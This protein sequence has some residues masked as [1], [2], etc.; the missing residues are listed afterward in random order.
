VRRPA[1]IVITVLVLTVAA[2]AAAAPPQ[3][4]AQESWPGGRQ[5]DPR[6]ERTVTLWGTGVPAAEVF[7]SI[8]K[9]TGVALGFDPP[10]DDNARICLN[11][12]LNPKEPPTL[13]E[14]LVQI[15][16][17]MDC[18]WG[19]EGEGEQ[20]RYVLLHTSGGSGALADWE[21]WREQALTQRQEREA[22]VEQEL[23]W[24]T[25]ARLPELREALDLSQEEAVRRYAGDPML[26]TLLDPP[27]RAVARFMLSLPAARIAELGPRMGSGIEWGELTAEQR[28]WLREAMRPWL[29]RCAVVPESERGLEYPWYDPA[30]VDRLGLQVSYHPQPTGLYVEV[31]PLI[32]WQREHSD[33]EMAEIPLLVLVRDPRE[34]LQM[35]ACEAVARR[36]FLGETIT[37]EQARR[38]QEAAEESRWRA[39]LRQTMDEQ[40]AQY[41]RVSAEAAARL[42]AVALPIEARQPYALWQLQEAVAAQSGFSMVS[43]CLWQPERS[44][45]VARRLLFP[46]AAEQL[47]AFSVLTAAC[48]AS[49]EPVGAWVSQPERA[50]CEWGD[51]GNILR[52]RSADRALWREAMLPRAVRDA[53]DRWMEPYLP[54][55]SQVGEEPPVVTVPLDVRGYA[56][57]VASLT[58]AQLA[59]G[60][61]LIYGDPTD[62]RNAYRQAMAR[63]FLGSGSAVWLASRIISSLD[64]RRWQQLQG[65][66]LVWGK[67][68]RIEPTP[69]DRDIT[70]NA[71]REG[72]VLHYEEGPALED[73]S[74]RRG[75]FYAWR[76]GWDAPN[77]HPP[78]D[79]PVPVEARLSL[80]PPKHL[81]P[82]PDGATPPLP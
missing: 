39:A 41:R 69:A 46:D 24:Q 45:I 70:W 30:E 40:L 9:Q 27:R 78:F 22:A 6:L 4:L 5:Y 66:G 31:S 38:I 23:W 63:E 19:V 7:A 64:D 15:G 8:T 28:E 11:A 56:P 61:N 2:H 57:L 68:V 54:G 35:P 37:D 53:M 75:R 59:F 43:D 26:L 76:D 3:W 55:L 52:F 77:V 73:Q 81:I 18:A 20:S 29:D 21:K 33:F 62:L 71:Y 10:D 74:H 48:V 42:S 58:R 79:D 47:D 34:P 60:R 12:Y 72:D 1:L 13:R 14:V 49:A 65:E 16:W 17:V 67:D 32:A 80:S 25:V 36:R 82:L 44:F 51:A 50:A